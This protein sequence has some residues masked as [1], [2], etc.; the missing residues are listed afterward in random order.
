MPYPASG[1]PFFE[2]INVSEVLERFENMCDNYRMFN[3]EKIRR[4]PWYCEMFTA[5]QVKSVDW[6]Y[7]TGL[8]QDLCKS[9]EEV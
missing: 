7:R 8:G 3:S 2:G 5:R 1:T 6:I 9:Q 4:L